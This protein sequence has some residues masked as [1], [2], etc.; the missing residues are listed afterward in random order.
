MHFVT[1]VVAS[2]V[3]SSVGRVWDGRTDSPCATIPP[4]PR[5]VYCAEQVDAIIRTEVTSRRCALDELPDDDPLGDELLEVVPAAP[6]VVV[7]EEPLEEPVEPADASVPVTSTWWPLCCESSESRPSRMYVDPLIAMLLPLPLPAVPAVDELGLLEPEPLEVEPLAP[8]PLA[9]A[10][11]ALEP[12]A[13]EPLAPGLLELE[14]LEPGL[15]ELEPV[16][17]PDAIDELEPGRALVSMN[18]PPDRALLEVEPAVPLVPVAPDAPPPPC[19]QPVTVIVRLA[20][21]V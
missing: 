3:D 16:A 11:P 10:P 7:D 12:P 17:P 6:L 8:A 5:V 2:G 15:V 13:L 14:L 20:L 19:R 21:E 9:P 1:E 4:L 18:W